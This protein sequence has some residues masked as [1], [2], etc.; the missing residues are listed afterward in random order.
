MWE[1]SELCGEK[2][3]QTGQ[4]VSNFSPLSVCFWWV[5]RGIKFQIRMADLGCLIS[6]CMSMDFGNGVWKKIRGVKG[7]KG[8][9]MEIGHYPDL[10][11]I[12]RKDV[13]FTNRGHSCGDVVCDGCSQRKQ[14]LPQARLENPHGLIWLM[15]GSKRKMREFSITME[16]L[17]VCSSM[18]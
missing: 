12:H 9:W 14:S 10:K 2:T 11:P 15:V 1:S 6:I 16:S 18:I 17:A 5:F 4:V 3:V 8:Y 13:F 7:R